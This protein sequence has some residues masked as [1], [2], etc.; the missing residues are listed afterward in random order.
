M[1]STEIKIPVNNNVV[2]TG[3]FT[4]PHNPRALIIFSHGSGSSRFSPRNQN[5][6]AVL[7]SDDFATL[8]IDLLTPEEDETYKNRFNIELLTERL[9]SVTNYIKEFPDIKN[10]PIGY[11]GASTGAASALK[12]AARLQDK[13]SAVISRGGRPDL[14]ENE[15]A[16]VKSPTLLIVGSLDTEVIILNDMAYQK[17][18]CDKEM[19]IIE[20]ASHL[21]EEPGKLKEVATISASWFNKKFV[22]FKTLIK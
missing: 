18:N 17:L 10:L 6:A 11:F 19:I 16:K 21:F 20:G 9:I 5:V 22:N 15:L 2:L 8:L 1:T 3:D 4:I 14:A 7:N 12:A 13:I